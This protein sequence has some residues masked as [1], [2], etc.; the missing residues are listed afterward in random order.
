[1][2]KLL[3]NAKSDKERNAIKNKDQFSDYVL[4]SEKLI[5]YP[6]HRGITANVFNKKKCFYVNNLQAN[7]DFD[8]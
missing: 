4:E 3:K 1:M 7:R 5:Y 8:F 6:V 2:A